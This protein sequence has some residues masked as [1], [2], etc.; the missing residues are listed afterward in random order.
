M[1]T[2]DRS[3]SSKASSPTA[4]LQVLGGIPVAET[5]QMLLPPLRSGFLNAVTPM[6]TAISHSN[7]GVIILDYSGEREQVKQNTKKQSIVYSQTIR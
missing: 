3:G 6:D 2:P 7:L 1:P 4:L 5:S